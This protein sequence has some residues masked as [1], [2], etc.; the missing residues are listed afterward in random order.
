MGVSVGPAQIAGG[1]LYQPAFRAQRIC[2]HVVLMEPLS[3]KTLQHMDTE[4]QRAVAAAER[5]LGVPLQHVTALSGDDRRNLILRASSPSRSVIVKATRDKN[6]RPQDAGAFESGPGQ[7]MGGEA[8]LS[9]H[10]PGNAPAFLGGDAELGLIVLG[11]LGEGLGRLVGPLLGD[12]AETAERALIAYATAI[13]QLHADTLHCIDHHADF[14]RRDF[15]AA[16]RRPF[17]SEA[18]RAP[19]TSHSL[20]D[21]ERLARSDS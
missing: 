20:A 16:V 6:Y 2:S 11:D 17:D 4:Q 19:M 12:S 7:G 3:G 14:L 15:P 8:F 1:R 21:R 13:G 9:Q 5:V 10:A 18:W